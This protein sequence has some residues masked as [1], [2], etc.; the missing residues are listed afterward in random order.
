MQTGRAIGGSVFWQRT[1]LR[2]PAY[3]VPLFL[4]LLRY[5]WMGRLEKTVRKVG[6]G[7]VCVSV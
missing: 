6:Q 4:L 3:Y 2:S 7:N 5:Y 1:R